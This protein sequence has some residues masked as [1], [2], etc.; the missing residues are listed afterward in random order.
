MYICK[1]CGQTGLM[2][3]MTYHFKRR[4]APCKHP[5]V[6]HEMFDLDMKR[7]AKGKEG[8]YVKVITDKEFDEIRKTGINPVV[9]KLKKSK[10]KAAIEP[11]V[12]EKAKKDAEQ[13]DKKS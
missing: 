9:E 6:T 11:E 13:P 3:D 1:L 7:L 10:A 4:D 12:L 2:L 8:T 5:E